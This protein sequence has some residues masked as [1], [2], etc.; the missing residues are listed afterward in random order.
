MRFCFL[1][2]DLIVYSSSG[3]LF[4]YHCPNR[5]EPSLNY[6]SSSKKE[7]LYLL[8][9]ARLST[10]ILF[11]NCFWRLDTQV[12]R[13]EAGRFDIELAK[14]RSR[15]SQCVLCVHWRSAQT[16]TH[17]RTRDERICLCR[18]YCWCNCYWWWCNRDSIYHT[19]ATQTDQRL[20]PHSF[21][22]SRHGTDWSD[23]RGGMGKGWKRQFGISL[24][25][26]IH[27]ACV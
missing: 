22:L 18:C 8:S 3:L 5:C 23:N 7:L 15:D 12:S 16:K 14:L 11:A 10:C 20:A 25:L 9:L 27:L 13:D 26:T 2:F 21:D 19:R 1:R 4:H 17:T 6:S 24:W